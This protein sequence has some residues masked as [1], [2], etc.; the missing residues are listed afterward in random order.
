MTDSA[1]QI[2]RNNMDSF[3]GMIENKILKKS[4]VIK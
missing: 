4:G 1:E 2:R 3:L